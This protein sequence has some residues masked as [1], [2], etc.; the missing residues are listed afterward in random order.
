MTTNNGLPSIQKH[1]GRENYTTCV[2][3][4]NSYLE[5]EELWTCVTGEETDAKKLVKA[6]AKIILL[7]DPINYMCT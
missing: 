7:I 2:F 4:I 5:H 1:L 6:K 3:A